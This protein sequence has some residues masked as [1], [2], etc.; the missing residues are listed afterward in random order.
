MQMDFKIEGLEELGQKLNIVQKAFPDEAEK[1]VDRMT[2]RL[3]K[4]VRDK[5]KQPRAQ[6]QV[7]KSYKK[8]WPK[9]RR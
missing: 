5:P 2:N 6:T 4:S 9:N 7:G 3:R 1:V 8:L